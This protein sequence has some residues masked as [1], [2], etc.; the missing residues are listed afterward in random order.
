QQ[1][2]VPYVVLD[3]GIQQTPDM[4]DTIG[5]MLGAGERGQTLAYHARQAID[6]LR[7]RL[8]IQSAT[9]RPPV[10]YG[11]GADGLTTGVAGSQVTAVID[12]AGVVN[13]AARLGRGEITRVTREQIFAWRPA[14]VI[15]QQRS[16]YNALLHSPVWRGLPAVAN[17]RIYL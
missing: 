15:A 9:E 17:K 7:G 10:Y 12:Q 13:V 3:G 1:T 14:I 11:L 6:G 8:L 2:G 4:L 5:A 16:F